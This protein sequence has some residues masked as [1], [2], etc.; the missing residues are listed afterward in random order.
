M[1]VALVFLAIDT[2]PN[3]NGN[4]KTF[5]VLFLV[6]SGNN[7]IAPPLFNTFKALSVA[8]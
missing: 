5:F 8:L 4:R 2:V 7:P 6:P 3:L 1:I